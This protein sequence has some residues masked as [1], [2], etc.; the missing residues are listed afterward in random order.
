MPLLIL[1]AA[2]HRYR[3]MVWPSRLGA[4]LRGR[5][6]VGKPCYPVAFGASDDF[7]WSVTL[8]LCQGLMNS[9]FIVSKV[10]ISAVCHPAHTARANAV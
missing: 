8:R 2:Y 9:T 6:S 3:V 10:A 4:W 5:G 1:L 7:W